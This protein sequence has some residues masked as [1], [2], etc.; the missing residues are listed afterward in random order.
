MSET[1]KPFRILSIDGG[2]LRGLIPIQVLKHIRQITGKPIAESFDLIAGTSTGGI[3]TV[4]L[5]YSEDNRQPKFDP[6]NQTEQF[7]HDIEQMY[8]KWGSTIFP[9]PSKN[10]FYRFYQKNIRSLIRP[11]FKKAGI[12]QVL[13]RY[14]GDARLNNCLKPILV[15]TYDLSRN[16]PIFFKSRYINPASS[17]E[18]YFNSGRNAKLMDICRATSAAPTYL[19]TYKF[20]YADKEGRDYFANVIDGGVYVNNPALAALIEILQYKQ[21]PIYNRPELKMEDIYVLSLGTGWTESQKS[22]SEDRQWGVL[23]WIKPLIDVMMAGNSQTVDN[24]LNE[25]LK[26]NYLRV[27]CHIDT[28]FSDMTDSSDLAL[29]HWKSRIY[30]QYLNNQVRLR[31]LEDFII[32]A[33]L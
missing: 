9:R 19:P 33:K 12:E 27:N 23:K 6:Y 16:E 32:R 18:E 13:S 25:L 8:L 11:Q 3:I 21:A 4:A 29:N 24:Q 14:L 1:A 22:P 5:T 28:E 2:G 15:S 26:V 30:D 31:E 10:I 7:L 17:Q 20:L